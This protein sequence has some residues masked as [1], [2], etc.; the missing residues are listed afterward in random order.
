MKEYEI[1]SNGNYLCG[2][3]PMWDHEKKLFYWSDL[4]TGCLYRYDPKSKKIDTIAEGK[5]VGGFALNGKEGFVCS[6]LQGLF[7]WDEANGFKLITDKYENDFLACN[8]RNS[9]PRRAFSFRN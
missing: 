4:S 7:F 5:N 8:R 2:E 6:T 3:S 1:V 9:G